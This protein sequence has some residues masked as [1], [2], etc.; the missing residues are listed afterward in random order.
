M[1]Q[2]LLMKLETDIFVSINIE[3]HN[4]SHDDNLYFFI[5]NNLM[6]LYTPFIFDKP[7]MVF[8]SINNIL[9]KMKL[10]V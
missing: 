8:L 2:I 6:K 3:S 5:S 1:T 7:S 10:N 9:L 4:L